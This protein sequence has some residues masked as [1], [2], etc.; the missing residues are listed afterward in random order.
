MMHVHGRPLTVTQF[1]LYLVRF[2]QPLQHG[3][4]FRSFISGQVKFTCP[5]VNS[6]GQSVVLN[7]D[8]FCILGTFGNVWRRFWLSHLGLGWGVSVLL[9][10]SGGERSGCC[11]TPCGMQRTAAPCSQCDRHWGWETLLWAQSMGHCIQGC[12]TL[13]RGLAVGKWQE[14]HVHW[15][16]ATRTWHPA[17]YAAAPS[18]CAVLPSLCTP[19]GR[20][21]VWVCH[22]WTNI[23]RAPAMHRIQRQSPVGTQ[24][25]KNQIHKCTF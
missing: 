7:L 6:L 12:L 3:G 14:L 24:E 8:W 23:Y 11:E 15:C 18:M 16:Y 20:R 21:C 13:P 2:R 22:F 19:R 10:A 17:L 5:F 4:C 9:L 25:V 1:W